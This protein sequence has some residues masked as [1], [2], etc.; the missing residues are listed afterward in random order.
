[1]KAIEI[2]LVLEENG[3]YK[4]ISL[5]GRS[6]LVVRGELGWPFNHPSGNRYKDESILLRITG[7]VSWQLSSCVCHHPY[8]CYYH[9]KSRGKSQ[10]TQSFV[11]ISCEPCQ[12]VR[13]HTK[14][15]E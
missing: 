7:S 10:Q 4:A 15:K 6:I 9:D 8:I 11:G 13:N 3:D 12:S 5:G 1:M 2:K 14:P